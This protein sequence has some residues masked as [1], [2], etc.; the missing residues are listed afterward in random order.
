MTDDPLAPAF[1]ALDDAN[2][3][4]ERLHAM[5]CEPGRSPR[6]ER[7]GATLATARAAVDRSAGESAAIDGAIEALQDAGS[8]LGWLQI[9]CCAPKRLPLYASMLEDLT[10]VQLT[11]N[12]VRGAAH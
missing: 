8:Q 6:M 12:A 7:L 4:L 1:T 11:L 10:T 3:T 9:G 2:A 5:C